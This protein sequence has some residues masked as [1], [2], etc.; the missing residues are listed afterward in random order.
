MRARCGACRAEVN[1]LYRFGDF[2][3]YNDGDYDG[4]G[5]MDGGGWDFGQAEELHGAMPPVDGAE[6][7]ASPS[8]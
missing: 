1:G 3:S 2:D 8:S 7:G 4:G 5:G 6:V